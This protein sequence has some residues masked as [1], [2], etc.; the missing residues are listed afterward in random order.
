VGL[1]YQINKGI[2]RPIEFRGLKAQYIA[3]LAIG[4][5]VLLVAFSVMYIAGVPVYLCVPVVLLAGSGLFMGVYRLSHRYGQYGLLKAI[6]FRQVPTAIILR[7]R[8]VFVR[9]NVRRDDRDNDFSRRSAGS[10]TAAKQGAG[11]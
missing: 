6:A 5:A 3:Y 7:S 4:L 2:N 11:R 8:K 1:I 10:G 9:L